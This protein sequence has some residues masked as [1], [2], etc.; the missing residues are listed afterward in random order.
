LVADPDDEELIKR[1]HA[2]EER[3]LE[4]CVKQGGSITG[5]HGVGIERRNF[6][7]LMYNADELQAMRDVK[8]V[9]DPQYLFNPGKIFPTAPIAPAPLPRPGE[10]PDSPFA[11]ASVEQAAEGVRACLSAEPPRRIRIRGREVSSGDLPGSDLVLSTRNLRGIR[12]YAPDD[13]YVVAGAGTPLAELQAE[14]ERDKMWVPLVSPW[15]EA[16]LGGIVSTNFNAPLR[17]RYGYG[18]IRDW[19][20]AATVVLP[21]GRVIRVGRPVVKNVAGYDM[22]KLFVGAH[23]TL[24]LIAELT[25]K[26][27]P[28]PRACAT[29]AF[30]VEEVERGLEWGKR[31]SRVCLG[32][33]ALLLCRGCALPGVATPFA[34]VYTVEGLAQDVDAELTE[35]GQALG[36]E[37]T[38][39]PIQLD[40]FS[41][42]ELWASWLGSAQPTATTVRIGTAPKDLPGLMRAAMPRLGEA[43]Y[44][45]DLANGLLYW[46]GLLAPDTLKALRD[47]ARPLGGYAVVLSSPAGVELDRWGYPPEGLDLMRALKRRWD[48]HGLFNPGAFLV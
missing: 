20:L 37:G 27:A 16:T 33:S 43:S 18:S 30:P 23:G 11:P 44:V 47:L 34:L 35:A 14:L 3:A 22:P 13:L 5:E 29:L 41:G 15:P 25:L 46:K 7:P 39:E 10:L 6:M 32:A 19:V 21:N 2:V 24:G 42:S 17:M 26:I 12:H 31:L 8:E 36:N 1:V 45:A 9:F 38:P 40:A 28:R 4:F 48:P